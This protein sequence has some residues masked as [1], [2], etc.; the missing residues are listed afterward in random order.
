MS[1]DAAPV[2]LLR[3]T[4]DSRRWLPIV[5]GVPEA[6]VLV[7]LLEKVEPARP[8]TVDLV[9]LV[10]DK[11][12]HAVS[13][14]EVTDL[15]E[16]IFVADLVVDD[17]L[18]ISARPSDAIAIALRT[19]VPVEV[20]NGVLDEASVD[21]EVSDDSEIEGSSLTFQDQEHTV[22]EFRAFLDEASPEDFRGPPG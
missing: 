21:L 14:V 17:R 15:R 13:R 12:G 2:M 16:G 10:I 4:V 6:E 1:P 22:E 7:A 5:I 8:S 18:R 11:L 19:G 9:G 3:E 20:D